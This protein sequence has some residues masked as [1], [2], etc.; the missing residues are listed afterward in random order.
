M[1]TKLE[2]HKFIYLLIV[3][4]FHCQLTAQT[5]TLQWANSFGSS[6]FNVDGDF[7]KGM[8]KDNQGYI[9]ITGMIQGTV[10]FDPSPATFNLSSSGI[11]KDIYTAKYDSSGY[12][13]WAKKVASFNSEDVVRTIT[14]DKNNN[15]YIGAVVNFFNSS[16]M[17]RKMDMNGNIIW[18]KFIAGQ[19]NIKNLLA[20]DNGLLITGTFV[21]TKDFDPST[22]VYNLSTPSNFF[23]DEAVFFAKYDFSG[24][25]IFAKKIV[26]HVGISENISMPYIPKFGING[27]IPSI[28][29]DNNGNIYLCDK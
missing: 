24:N 16:A 20:T 27:G 4:L 9:Y 10:D 7:V 22:A 21:G 13:I 6:L 1:Q 2:N 14:I 26:N 23:F 3:L 11:D 8:V 17:I 28:T 12:L 19:V 25:F 15:I 18:T 5:P 29:S